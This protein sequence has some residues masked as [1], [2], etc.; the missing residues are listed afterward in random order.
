MTIKILFNIG[1]RVCEGKMSCLRIHVICPVLDLG[2]FDPK[3]QYFTNYNDRAV[4]MNH[5]EIQNIY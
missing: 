3:Y 4:V 1:E 5:H 2:H